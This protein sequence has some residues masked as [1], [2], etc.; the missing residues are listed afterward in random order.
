MITMKEIRQRLKTPYEYTAPYY[1]NIGKTRVCRS[2][3]DL[4]VE[5]GEDTTFHSDILAYIAP[6]PDELRAWIMKR[7]ANSDGVINETPEHVIAYID[8]AHVF[9][10]GVFAE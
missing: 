3:Y 5:N 8:V 7:I 4:C 1:Y 10:F 9:A 6:L 2:Y